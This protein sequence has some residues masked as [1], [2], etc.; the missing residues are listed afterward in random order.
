MSVYEGKRVD[1]SLTNVSLVTHAVKT[2]LTAES[3][4]TLVTGTHTVPMSPVELTISA[5][6]VQSE[7]IERRS[8]RNKEAA[9]VA[10]SEASEALELAAV[11]ARLRTSYLNEHKFYTSMKSSFDEDAKR[12]V[13]SLNFAF[14]SITLALSGCESISVVNGLQDTVYYT[15]FYALLCD[16]V[17]ANTD[18]VTAHQVQDLLTDAVR[19]LG[20]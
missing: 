7:L 6:E 11:Q 5:T 12:V 13:A 14:K 17:S 10:E 2:F 19:G 16:Y 20:A 4:L 18:I 9:A 1:A 15:D 3:L 8:E